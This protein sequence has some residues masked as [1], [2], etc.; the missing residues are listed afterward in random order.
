[1]SSTIA[2]DAAIFRAQFP[3]FADETAFPDATLEAYWDQATCYV[4]D[5][6]YGRLSGACRRLALNNMTAHLCQLAQDITNGNTVGIANSAT[7]GSVSVSLSPPPFG[8]DQW[9]WWLNL[10]PYGAALEAL[11]AQAAIGG[12]YIGGHNERGSFRRSGGGFG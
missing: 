4:S 12:F 9:S 1:M 7:V 5:C 3:A 10:T 2:F 6:D 8:T 11:L